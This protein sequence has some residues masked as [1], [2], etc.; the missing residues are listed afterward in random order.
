[1]TGPGRPSPPSWTLEDRILYDRLKLL[2]GNTS[3]AMIWAIVQMAFL[4]GVLGLITGFANWREISLW[5]ALVLLMRVLSMGAARRNLATDPATLNLTHQVRGS[6]AVAVVTGCVWALLVWV[7][8]PTATPTDDIIII[9]V[10]ASVLSSSMAVMAATRQV[11]A[12]FC[13]GVLMTVLARGAIDPTLM[14]IALCVGSVIFVGGLYMQAGMASRAVGAS[15]ELR[16]EN[17]DLIRKLGAEIDNA[18]GAQREAAAANAAKS[19]FLAAASHDLRQ[20]VH[21]LGLFLEVLGRGPLSLTQ[22]NVL[23]SARKASEAS[24]EMLNTLL[25]FSRIEAGVIEPQVRAFAL[26]PLLNKVENDLGPQADA[27]S[28]TYRSR[29]TAM[30][31]RSDPALVELI[32]R[33]LVSNAIRYTERGGILV[34]CRRRGGQAVIEVWDTGI[35]IEPAQQAEVFREFH[36]LGNPERD[37]RNGLGLGL[38]IAYGLARTLGHELSLASDPGRGSV[39]RLA[40]PISNEAAPPAAAFVIEDDA[41]LSGLT[42]PRILVID[43]DEAV[44]LGMC[45]L[46]ADWGFDCDAVESLEEALVAAAHRP[47]G[48]IIS[49]YRLRGSRTGAEAIAAMRA[50]LGAQ[51]PALLITGDTAPERLREAR[52]SGVPLLHKP[53]S[54][55]ALY[56]G[57][58]SVLETAA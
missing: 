22:R 11:F 10:L 57:L 16:F 43:D 31:V 34:G 12:G 1:M 14:N 15:I 56:Q 50:A 40:L 5:V 23:S 52:A 26:Q 17:L 4:G 51:I 55:S 53:V 21:A 58:A 54:P 45:G 33:N 24:A 2:W 44:R 36:Q 28:M 3:G 49:D 46:M 41:R 29:E 32:L 7:M 19:R 37:R 30:V 39:F 9:A 47:P 48:L 35:G 20:P 38:S 18:H 8:P 27:K 6:I 13:V 25:D 42:R